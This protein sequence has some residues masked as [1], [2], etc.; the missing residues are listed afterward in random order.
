MATNN[1]TVPQHIGIEST[2][3][4]PITAKVHPAARVAWGAAT[5]FLIL[6]AAL[7]LL[8]PDYDPSWRMISEYAIGRNGWVMTL[9]FLALALSYASLAVALRAQLHT[10]GGKIGWALLLLSALGTLISAI[11]TTDPITAGPDEVTTRG[12]LHGLGFVSVA[13][14]PFAATLLS[15]SLVREHEWFSARRSLALAAGFVWLALLVF[16]GSLATM[17]RGT[18]GPHVVIGWQNRLL[19]IAYVVWV[20]VVAWRMVRGSRSSRR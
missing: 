18:F 19:I 10:M 7:H 3:V 14:F 15:R 2:Q 4:V 5:L 13:I 8:K 9:A 11:F 17:F 1:G 12:M 6:L 16:A 20:L